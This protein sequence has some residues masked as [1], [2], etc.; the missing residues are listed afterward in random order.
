MN[1]ELETYKTVCANLTIVIKTQQNMIGNL[2]KLNDSMKHEIET[3]HELNSWLK[4][5]SILNKANQS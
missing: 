2:L 4:T 1:T 5:E 3:L